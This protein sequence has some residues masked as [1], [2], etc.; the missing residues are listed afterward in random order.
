MADGIA[1]GVDRSIEVVCTDG[2][3]EL[4]APVYFSPGYETCDI[5][6]SFGRGLSLQGASVSLIIEGDDGTA[7]YADSD[8]G[9]GPDRSE[10][11]RWD[12]K[13]GSG[14]FVTPQNSPYTATLDVGGVITRTATIKV[15]VAAI[16]V[17]IE[18]A[19]KIIMNDPVH[20]VEVHAL[21]NLKTS[22]GGSTPAVMPLEV[23][24]TFMPGAD[25]GTIADTFEYS[26]GNYL[27]K[28]SDPN[29]AFWEPHPKCLATTN[30]DDSYVQTCRVM[31]LS[32]STDPERGM[33][34]VLFKP[35][36]VGGDTYTL[37]AAIY[38]ADQF[39]VLA[40]Q[41]SAEITVWRKIEYNDVYT[42]DGENYIDA[43]TTHPEIAPAY[44]PSAYVL[45]TR[46]AVHTLAAAL[47]V[48][49]IGLYKSGGGMKT[50]PADF[51]PAKLETSPNDLDPTPQE[52]AAYASVDPAKAADKAQAKTDI[53]AKAQ[54]WFNAIVADYGKSL[55]DWFADAAVPAGNVLLAVQYYH[56]KLSDQGDGATNFWPAG[57][58]I[59]L[60][61]PGS[62]L[63]KAGDPDKDTWRVVA[64]FNRGSISV[65]FKNY[66]DA[67]DLQ[68]TCRHEIGHGTKSAFKRDDF[69]TGDHSASSLMK[70]DGGG[71]N[72]FSNDDIKIL[73]GIKP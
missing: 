49:Y 19:P 20:T 68:N 62:G 72:L 25:N 36:G 23:H 18:G 66:P 13:D 54:K 35:S 69:G 22:A 59:N 8:L 60:A 27:G 6:L 11:V 37:S 58:S 57:I 40:D 16:Q 4:S 28:E 46:G 24:W 38:A 7:V 3:A 10:V 14:N 39:T 43:A 70:Y 34:F 42:M 50:W 5:T 1:V 56:P 65:I 31:T 29:A 44:E 45:Y 15:E 51:S 64:G 73:R 53:E 26:A 21:V 63:N 48:K 9:Q 52:L 55:D 33:A 67:N 71:V 47:T 12:G 32:G 41:E 61:N 30:S 17:V 2:S